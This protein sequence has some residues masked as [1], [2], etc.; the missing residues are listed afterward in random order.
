MNASIPNVLSAA[1]LVAAPG[2]VIVAAV[3]SR[4]GFLA[5]FGAAL[6]TDALDGYLARRLRAESDLGRKLD[7]WADYAMLAAC[8]LGLWWLWPD[9]TRREWPWFAA[10]LA[11]CLAIVVVG[12]LCWR[13]VP[14]YHTWLAKALAVGFPIALLPLLAGWSAIPFHVLIALQILSAVEEFAIACLLPGHS[15]HVASVWHAWSMRL[16]TSSAN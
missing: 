11:G 1:R 7:S 15:G 8:A 3:G 2:L 9:V 12:L 6:L 16:K 4:A 5:L 14:G 10:G 13:K